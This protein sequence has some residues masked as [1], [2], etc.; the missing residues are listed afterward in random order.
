MPETTISR[1]TTASSIKG[2]TFV[3]A[4]TSPNNPAPREAARLLTLLGGEIVPEVTPRLDHLVVFGRQHD[5]LTDEE[6]Q[7][8]TLGEAGRTIR[9]LD[10]SNFRD[11]L[12]PT[13]DEALA[14]LRGGDEGLEQWRLRRNDMSQTPIDLSGVDLRGANLSH[15]VLY[16]VNFE[17][18]DLSGSDLSRSS[19]GELVR[20]NLDGAMLPGAYV[21]HLTDCTARNADFSG[22]RFNPAVVVRTDFTGSNLSRVEGSY[23]RSEQ[24]VFRD[25]DL[26]RAMLQDS[27]FVGAVFDGA[28][29]ANAFLED[30]D[31]TGATFRRAR[32]NQTSLTRAKLINADLTGADLSGANLAGVDLTGAMVDGANFEGANLYAADLS[33]IGSGQP[34]GLVHPPPVAR[35]RIGPNMRRL[36]ARWRKRGSLGMS[37]HIDP[38]GSGADFV[39]LTIREWGRDAVRGF[40]SAASGSHSCQA[41]TPCEVMLE[42]AQLWPGA[43]LYLETLGVQS[44]STRETPKGLAELALAAWHEAFAL[45]L[46]SPAERRSRQAE[47]RSRF[48]GLLRG[49]P[50][51]VRQWNV[52]RSEALSRASHFR[53]ANLAGCDLRSA[54]LGHHLGTRFG[55]LDFAGADFSSANLTAGSLSDCSLVNASFRGAV[56]DG[57]GCSGANFR[58]ADFEGASLRGCNLRGSRCRGTSFHNA[59]LFRADFGH[60]DLRGADLSSAKLERTRFEAAKWDATTLFPDGFDPSA[61]PACGEAPLD[62]KIGSRIRVLNGAFA[63]VEGTV[64]EHSEESGKVVVEV[65]IWGR[66][67]PVELEFDDVELV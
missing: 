18:A 66:S 2:R 25:A 41:R 21:P 15:I 40:S 47:H 7:V 11:L 59:D 23:T 10:W 31:L 36:E 61:K 46:P 3:L 58:R 63:G 12:T 62:L 45:P 32:L 6:R 67:V 14:L 5:R 57:V 27:A 60:A 38:D 51:G 56:L 43:E 39:Q 55:G 20:V 19:L 17:G 65:I 42:L 33:A 64:K 13:R 35:E 49:G 4:G 50:E 9:I 16:R 24:A 44:G 26:S 30:C 22:V 1:N 52:L 34:L 29:L 53:R 37:L 28:N 48:L 8:E 54:N